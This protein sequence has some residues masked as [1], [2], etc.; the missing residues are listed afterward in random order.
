MFL[1]IFTP[2]L[3]LKT[4][5]KTL[6]ELSGEEFVETIP[7]PVVLS[8]ETAISNGDSSDETKEPEVTV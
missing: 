8:K 3:V 6:E 1:G 7:E 5:K 2:L 4:K